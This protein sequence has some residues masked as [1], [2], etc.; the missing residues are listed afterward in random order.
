MA[1]PPL[2]D[3]FADILGKAARGQGLDPAAFE[4]LVSGT[5]D[6]ARAQDACARLGLSF[7]ALRDLAEGRWQPQPPRRPQG[8]TAFTT[9]FA[10]MTVNAYLAWDP[11]SGLA[12]AFDTGAD[13]SEMLRELKTRNLKLEAL[14]LTHTHG[15]HV[16]EFDRLREQTGCRSFACRLEP[17]EGAESFEPGRT[18]AVGGLRIESRLTS[19]HSP[20][21]TTYHIHG[22]DAPVTITGDALFAGSVGGIKADYTASL[23]LIRREILSR[24]DHT[25]LCPGHGPITTV[26]E[27]KLHNPFFA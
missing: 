17:F 6:P 24:P 10:G 2:E 8:L 15:D 16:F 4:P 12:A 9:P 11:A 7:P 23:A 22:L 27:E 1:P 13:C 26:G 5:W 19:G 20:G 18:F 25:L 3:T 14:F 21:G